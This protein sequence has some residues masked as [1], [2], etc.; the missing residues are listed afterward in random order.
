[1]DDQSSDHSREIARHYV[2]MDQRFCLMD[3]GRTPKDPLGPWLPRNRGLCASRGD[4]VSFLDADDLWRHDKLNKQLA[5]MRMRNANLCVSAYVRFADNDGTVSEVRC[6]PSRLIP[7]LL[8]IVNP[9]PLSSVVVRKDL[10]R[11]GFR[12][13]PHEDHDA[14]QRIY[15]FGQMKYSCVQEPVTA[16]RI[17]GSNLTGSW[18]N[19]LAMY[20]DKNRHIALHRR[21]IMTC[22]FLA[23][24]AKYLIRSFPFRIRKQ[25]LYSFG[26]KVLGV[27]A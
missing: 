24:Q 9:I 11:A 19:K 2:A 18:R 6:P 7:S 10:M 14:W 17:H 1:V 5:L 4:Y 21:W 20:I 22:L 3:S 8:E 26:F 13:V 23:L 12:P 16:Y 27:S 15:S 25:N